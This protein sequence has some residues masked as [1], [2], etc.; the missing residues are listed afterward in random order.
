[1]SS[2][3]Q[4]L[5]LFLFCLG[6]LGLVVSIFGFAILLIVPAV[7]ETPIQ[8]L[9]VSIPGLIGASCELMSLSSSGRKQLL[10][11]NAQAREQILRRAQIYG[12]LFTIGVGLATN[13]PLVMILVALIALASFYI[14]VISGKFWKRRI[15][16]LLVSALAA[17]RAIKFIYHDLTI[18]IEPGSGWSVACICLLIGIFVFFEKKT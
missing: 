10:P 13:E 4:K 9:L 14:F 11:R 16:I 1:M 8:R 15:I 7:T 17:P 12:I 18:V 3:N 6:C 2:P 5:A